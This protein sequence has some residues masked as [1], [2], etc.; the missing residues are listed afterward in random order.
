M[1]ETT[2]THFSIDLGTS[3]EK[4]PLNPKDNKLYIYSKTFSFI[5]K[6]NKG[7]KPPEKEQKPHNSNTHKWE[8]NLYQYKLNLSVFIEA[9]FVY[10]PYFLG[11]G[12]LFFVIKLLCSIPFIHNLILP[13][14]RLQMIIALLAP[15]V[16]LPLF[17]EEC[18]E[19]RADMFTLLMTLLFV[20]VAQASSMAFTNEKFPQLL[21]SI[22]LSKTSLEKAT[23]LEIMNEKDEL[24][25]TILRLN[26]NASL[27]YFNFLK[28][29][30][31]NYSHMRKL[32]V[33]PNNLNLKES[34]EEIFSVHQATK[35]DIFEE[36]M[37]FQR[38]L[39]KKN[40]FTKKT[41][42]DDKKL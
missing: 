25:S 12:P 5:N 39:F 10:I 19:F 14:N 18:N 16:Y 41:R 11:L 29:D 13:C 6:L 1:S 21:N 8:A 22:K 26:T 27:L 33:D 31:S 34:E 4:E 2:N 32:L 35:Q 17:V 37:N 30:G 38:V 40:N 9:L 42:F 20:A 7:N 3:S 23:K 24:Q 15:F 36:T 28:E